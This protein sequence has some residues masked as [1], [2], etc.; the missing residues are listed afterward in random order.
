MAG[1]FVP[2]LARLVPG[3]GLPP[4]AVVVTGSGGDSADDGAVTAPVSGR[5]T[6]AVMT[7]LGTS[8]PGLGGYTEATAE[9]APIIVPQVMVA[10]R[11]AI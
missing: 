8:V 7:P 10:V 5:P 11:A 9:D 4:D 1:T 3:V 6:P 2:V